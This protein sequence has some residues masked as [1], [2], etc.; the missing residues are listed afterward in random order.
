MTIP[1]DNNIIHGNC[2]EVL[3]QRASESV[4][5]VLTDPPYLA[6]YRSRDGRT[7]PGDDTDAWL[8]PAF[9][10][11]H[12]VLERD[13]FAVSFYGWPHADRF[14]RVYR[15][16]GF[17]VVGHF[18][19]PKRYSS[20]SKFVKYQHECA[21]LLAKGYPKQP[22]DTIGDVIPWQYTGNKLHPTQK[23]LSVLSP[24]VATFS[25]LNGLVLDPFAGSGSTLVAARAAGRRFLGIELDAGY[26]AIARRRLDAAADL[27]A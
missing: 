8:A 3:P 16:A 22:K 9:A 25:T 5:F 23:P 26:H 15:A 2:L 4:N 13:S 24:L 27:A 14:L 11:I 20:A 6:N 7:V 21:Y 12:R 1:S 17:R 10:E 18:T 19:F